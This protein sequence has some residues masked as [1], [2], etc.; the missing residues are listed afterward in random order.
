[1]T[2]ETTEFGLSTIRQISVNV[3]DVKKAIDF[4]RDTLGM[5]FLF[6]VPNMAFFDCDGV[7]LMLALPDRPE[8]DH[9]S[10]IIYFKVLDIQRAYDELSARGVKFESKPSLIARLS[11]H[12]L[13]L[14][15]FRDV[16]NNLLALM[17]EVP[18][19]DH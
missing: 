8:F 3:H 19:D 1:M 4:Y 11:D 14:V 18:R 17:S 10:S 16:D 15:D 7:R 5:K 2:E 12:D 13:W 9:P 6:E